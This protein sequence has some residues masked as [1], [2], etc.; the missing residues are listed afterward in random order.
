MY[1]GKTTTA[2]K[3]SISISECLKGE[4]RKREEEKSVKKVFVRNYVNLNVSFS[5]RGK[6]R[7]K[8]KK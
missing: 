6:Y 8:R 4:R 3:D 2:Q 7:G 5:K 1:C